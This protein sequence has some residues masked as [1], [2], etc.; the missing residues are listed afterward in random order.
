M[1]LEMPVP[2][3]TFTKI[4]KQDLKW[5]PYQIVTRHKFRNLDCVRRF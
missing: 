5:Y 4:M 3:I 1:M 2:G